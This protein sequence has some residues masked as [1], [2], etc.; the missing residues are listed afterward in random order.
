[1]V[2]LLCFALAAA[3]WALP[4]GAAQVT[5]RLVAVSDATF[6]RPHDVVPSPDGEY[7]YVADVDHHVVQVL[8]ARSLE[9]LG[10]IG[11]GELRSPHDVALDGAGRL[12]VADSGN[13]R[14]VRYTL[15]GGL[16]G[17]LE[18][19][20][21]AGLSSPEGVA[22]GPDGRLY[23]ANAGSHTVV[24]FEGD[25]EAGRVGGWGDGPGLF[26]R[27]HDLLVG[28]GGEVYVADPGND[29]IQVLDGALQPRREI[30]GEAYRFNEPKYLT[31]DVRGWLYVADEYNDRLRILDAGG[32]Q[33]ESIAQARYN[34]TTVALSQPE[35]VAVQGAAL[36]VSD[37]SNNRILRFRLEDI[38][39]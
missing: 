27:P 29:R 17:T 15:E 11:E 33:I 16:R 1:M 12:L 35:G 25:R 4:A 10:R 23:V 22:P 32:R 21:D 8:D 31:L 5:P 38:R 36:W 19:V 9:P 13:D 26:K 2:R 39:E 24:V 3:L 20:W 28:P 6:A 37:T 18:R 34:G 30:G 7:L 14:I